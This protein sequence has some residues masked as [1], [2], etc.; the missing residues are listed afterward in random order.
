[1][2]PGV[3]GG[4]VVDGWN[5][6]L[7]DARMKGKEDS[8]GEKALWTCLSE[9]AAGKRGEVKKRI[10]PPLAERTGSTLAKTEVPWTDADPTSIR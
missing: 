8:P 2:P 5:D 1:M 4:G 3:S 10:V 6:E 9:K 7:K